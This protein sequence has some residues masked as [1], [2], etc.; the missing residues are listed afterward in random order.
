MFTMLAASTPSL[1]FQPGPRSAGWWPPD[2][3]S[4]TGKT[5]FLQPLERVKADKREA[6]SKQSLILSRYLRGGW[7]LAP[8]G[9]SDPG[10]LLP[11]PLRVSCAKDPLRQGDLGKPAHLAGGLASA[12][13]DR[14]THGYTHLSGSEGSTGQWGK[15]IL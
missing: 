10:D 12:H 13:G 4:A 2:A 14:I 8:W 9:R 15:G 6:V 1:L 3:T 7:G 5:V 11:P